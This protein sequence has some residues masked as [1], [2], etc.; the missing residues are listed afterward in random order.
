[1]PLKTLL[2]ANGLNCS[3]DE[4]VKQS[5]IAWRHHL[6]CQNEYK[7]DKLLARQTH[8]AHVKI[9]MSA[10]TSF[11]RERQQNQFSHKAKLFFKHEGYSMMYTSYNV[12]ANSC[13]PYEL[14]S[15]VDKDR[16]I[17]LR[18]RCAPLN[19]F[20]SMLME[21][22]PGFIPSPHWSKMFIKESSSAKSRI[23]SRSVS[24]SRS[25]KSPDHESPIKSED[26]PPTVKNATSSSA[27]ESSSA[28]DDVV[29]GTTDHLSARRAKNLQRGPRFNPIFGHNSFY[30]PRLVSSDKK[31]LADWLWRIKKD[32]RQELPKQ[33]QDVRDEWL[34][35]AE[36]ERIKSGFV[37]ACLHDVEPPYDKGHDFAL[38]RYDE[39][40]VSNLNYKISQ[41]R[42]R[43]A[44]SCVKY[45]AAQ[46]H[47][48]A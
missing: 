1:M 13:T 18:L 45:D 44:A 20:Y 5:L 14:M 17:L 31:L 29:W 3:D 40:Y 27:K 46:K 2:G 47:A 25:S 10:L 26:E 48:W 15:K 8:E 43:N 21:D 6:T 42:E 34:R 11:K 36:N 30:D 12:P 33:Y 22:T 16:S 37:P 39:M 24:G 7:P 19:D 38:L 28:K 41:L 23:N 4:L 35:N 32:K 9:L